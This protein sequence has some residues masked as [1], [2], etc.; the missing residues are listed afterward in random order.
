MSIVAET[1]VDVCIDDI[2]VIMVT[3]DAKILGVEYGKCFTRNPAVDCQQR[4]I[5]YR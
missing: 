4:P 2:L 1:Y 3:D 5:N